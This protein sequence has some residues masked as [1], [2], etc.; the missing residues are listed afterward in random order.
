MLTFFCDLDNILFDITKK[1]HSSHDPVP[2]PNV[3][4]KINGS[5]II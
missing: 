2:W 4:F 5:N 3:T 1:C